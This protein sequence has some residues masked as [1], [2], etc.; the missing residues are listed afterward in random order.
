MMAYIVKHIIKWYTVYYVVQFQ[1]YKMDPETHW[2]LVMLDTLYI[3]LSTE[4]LN[5]PMGTYL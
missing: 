5:V 1:I 4:L 2:K 3:R